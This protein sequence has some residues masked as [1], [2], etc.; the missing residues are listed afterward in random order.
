MIYKILLKSSH[1]R[2][3]LAINVN[4]HKFKEKEFIK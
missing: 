1:I 2:I 4:N 3:L